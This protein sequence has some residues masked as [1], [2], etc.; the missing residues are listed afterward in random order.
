MS[1]YS[2][3]SSSGY[4]FDWI[5]NVFVVKVATTVLNC[6]RRSIT[7]THYYCQCMQVVKAY[8]L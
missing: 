2:S 4:R 3:Y 5:S 6:L 1:V 7:V 8:G